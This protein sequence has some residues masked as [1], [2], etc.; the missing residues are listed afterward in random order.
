MKLSPEVIEAQYRAGYRPPTANLL[1]YCVADKVYGSV[2]A[3]RERIRQ[4]CAEYEGDWPEDE[5]REVTDGILLNIYID[6]DGRRRS[7]AFL[8]DDEELEFGVDIEYVGDA[9]ERGD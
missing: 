5:W 4:I 1:C 3:I 7:T 2:D 8:A 9:I 6:D